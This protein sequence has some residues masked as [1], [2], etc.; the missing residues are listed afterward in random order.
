MWLTCFI[1]SVSC[2]LFAV[3]IL[4]FVNS[5]KYSKKRKISFFNY[6][7]AGVFLAA[8]LFSF[9]LTALQQTIMFGADC[10]RF[11]YRYL[12]RCRFLLLD[13]ILTL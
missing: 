3:I 2:I 8:F 13:A 10:I 5:D 11:Y 4:L 6:L 1:I 7:F 12:I 9:L